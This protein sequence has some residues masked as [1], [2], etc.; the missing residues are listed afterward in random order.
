MWAGLP[1][2]HFP[3]STSGDLAR[4][5][6]IARSFRRISLL[7]PAHASRECTRPENRLVY[8]EGVITSR[9]VN[10]FPRGSTPTAVSSI[11][12]AHLNRVP[13]SFRGH[14]AKQPHT[15]KRRTK[16]GSLQTAG[17]YSAAYNSDVVC[18]RFD[19]A[20]GPWEVSADSVH[21][22]VAISPHHYR[23]ERRHCDGG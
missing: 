5:G 20:V 17:K 4:Y 6:R 2:S 16:D 19:D 13:G 14:H 12:R 8:K 11:A 15:P 10:V 18:S 23:R 3:I 1:K 22:T 21:H 9:Q 7:C